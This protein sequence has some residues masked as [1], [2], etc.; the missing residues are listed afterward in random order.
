MHVEDEPSGIVIRDGNRMYSP[1]YGWADLRQCRSWFN[2]LAA[3]ELVIRELQA[4][5]A[6]A[7]AGT[8]AAAKVADEKQTKRIRGMDEGKG[9]TGRRVDDL[10]AA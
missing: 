2:S 5:K 1:G 10:F 6:D 8:S 9:D 3:A 4:Q 7:E